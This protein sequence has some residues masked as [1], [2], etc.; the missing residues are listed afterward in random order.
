MALFEKVKDETQ[1][2]D[3]ALVSSEAQLMVLL[4]G[5][6]QF[7]AE[8]TISGEL[9]ASASPARRDTD[10]SYLASWTDG[11]RVDVSTLVSACGRSIVFSNMNHPSTAA[12]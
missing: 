2:P 8:F 5:L 3:I 7:L 1:G 9:T 10:Q 11:N 6:N 12:E 4:V